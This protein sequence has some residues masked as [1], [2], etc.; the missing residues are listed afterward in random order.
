MQI[1]AAC[2]REVTSEVL[3]ATV[4]LSIYLNAPEKVLNNDTIDFA[5]Y[6]KAYKAAKKKTYWEELQEGLG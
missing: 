6:T 3:Q 4:L 1:T 2:G 5:N